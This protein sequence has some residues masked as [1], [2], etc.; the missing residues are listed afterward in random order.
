[1]LAGE[2]RLVKRDCVDPGH[3]FGI[4][5]DDQ[6][7]NVDTLRQEDT[8]LDI[9]AVDFRYHVAYEFFVQDGADVVF[10]G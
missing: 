5:T 6:I 1:M 3:V 7:Q 4:F 9:Q 2:F 8:F 10:P